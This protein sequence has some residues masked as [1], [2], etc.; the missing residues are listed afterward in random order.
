MG[1]AVYGNGGM[2]TVYKSNPFA[3]FGASG[4]AGI[5]LRQIF[6]TPTAAVRFAPGHSLGVSP[7]IVVQ[8]FRATGI[9]PFAAASLAPANF[10]N[11]GTD[12]SAGAGVRVGYLGHLG[13]KVSLGAF[14]Q[15]KIWTGHFDKYAGLFAGHGGFDVPASYGAGSRSS[16][17]RR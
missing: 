5:D 9:Q 2:N 10:T 11:R 6:I 16:R 17:R 8:G 3:S 15:S 14:Y 4:P 1:I 12:W 13:D 7:I